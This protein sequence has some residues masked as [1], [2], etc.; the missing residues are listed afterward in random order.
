MEYIILGGGFAFAAAIQPGP[1]Q[2]F[3]LSSVVRKGWRHTLP[4]SLSPLISD[5]PIALLAL[6]VL[7]R[8]P[9]AMSRVLMGAGGLFLVYLAW[10]TFR[11][12][13]RNEPDATGPD[14][15]PPRT[16]MQAVT[17]NLLNPNPYIGW[18]LVLGPA[19]VKAWREAPANAAALVVAFYAT[20]VVSLACIIVLFGA[21]RFLGPKKRRALV[22]VSALVLAVL[23]IYRIASSLPS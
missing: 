11:Q 9:P 18:S 6:L 8:I 14:H 22:L 15:S 19:A 12:W 3:L 10:G 13:R 4:A 7:T 20:M 2:A 5:G 23:G 17:V 21:T 1:L 16:L